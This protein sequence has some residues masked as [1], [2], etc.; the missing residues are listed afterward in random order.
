MLKN[1]ILVPLLLAIFAILSCNIEAQAQGQSKLGFGLAY[2]TDIEEIGLQVRGDF[3]LGPVASF[4]PNFTYFFVDGPFNFYTLNGDFHW[5]FYTSGGMHIYPLVGLNVTFYGFEDIDT[6]SEL[7]IN[8][9]GGLHVPITSNMDLYGEIKTV[10]GDEIVDQAVVSFGL[11][12][13]IGR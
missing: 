4:A 12:F 2:G 7:G 11:L 1:K 10:L 6:D 13:D 9:G 5:N 3:K 8:L